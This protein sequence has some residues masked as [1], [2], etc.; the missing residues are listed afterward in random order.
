MCSWDKVYLLPLLCFWEEMLLFPC[1]KADSH[2][3]S[4]RKASG[5][6]ATSVTQHGQASVLAADISPPDIPL[7]GQRSSVIS[8]EQTPTD[9]F[10]GTLVPQDVPWKNFSVIIFLFELHNTH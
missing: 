4:F 6:P 1:K 7:R 3:R 2:G 8:R 9:T 5:D 10:C